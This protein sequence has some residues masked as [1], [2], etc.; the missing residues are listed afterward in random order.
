MDEAGCW[1]DDYAFDGS[2]GVAQGVVVWF[3][4]VCFWRGFPCVF[5]RHSGLFGVIQGG[6][7][8]FKASDRSPKLNCK[9]PMNQNTLVATCRSSPNSIMQ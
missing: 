7:G 4:L 3:G 1:I 2:R 8:L 6:S 5:W 9:N